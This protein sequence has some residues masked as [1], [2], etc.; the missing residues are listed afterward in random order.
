VSEALLTIDEA[1]RLLNCSTRTVRR[2]LAHPDP[3]RRLRAY[4]VGEDRA[5]RIRRADL[6]EWLERRANT[7]RAPADTA[8]VPTALRPVRSRGR[9]AGHLI[10]ESG[11]GR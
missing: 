8:A 7:P 11:M 9:R 1:A 6:E 4:Q 5:W 2:A 10:V 3:E